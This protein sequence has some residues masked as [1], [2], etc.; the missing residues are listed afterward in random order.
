MSRLS[1]LISAA[2]LLTGCAHIGPSRNLSTD[3][4]LVASALSWGLRVPPRASEYTVELPAN[5]AADAIVAAAAKN[6]RLVQHGRSLRR[7]DGAVSRQTVLLTIQAPQPAT[8]SGVPEVR[9]P[10]T[11]SVGGAPPTACVVRIRLRSSDPC[12]WLFVAEGDE[13]C[14]TRPGAWNA[15]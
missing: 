3:E 11:F 13:H 12:T 4:Q 14:W 8:G 15:Q 6:D 10:F 5:Y 2:G 7:K 9:V 1:A